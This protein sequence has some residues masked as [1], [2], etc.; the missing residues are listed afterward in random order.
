MALRMKHRFQVVFA[1]NEQTTAVIGK[2]ESAQKDLSGF[3][4][5]QELPRL[6]FPEPDFWGP[7][8]LPRSQ[9]LAAFGPTIQ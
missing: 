2:V 5:P 3:A 4:T 6:N 7:W 1:F 9:L 8:A